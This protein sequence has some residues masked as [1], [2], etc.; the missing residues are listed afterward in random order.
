MV[1]NQDSRRRY[2]LLLDLVLCCTLFF[3]G[4]ST[5]EIYLKSMKGLPRMFPG[6]HT[7]WFHPVVLLA[8]GRGYVRITKSFPPKLSEFLEGKSDVFSCEDLPAKDKLVTTSPNSFDRH[9][10]YLMM[11]IAF[12]WRISGVITWSGLIPLLSF[13]F[14]I[15]IAASY[16]IFRLGMGRVL[17]VSGATLLAFSGMHLSNLIYLRDFSKEP[18]FLVFIFILVVLVTQ[19]LVNP[20]KLLLISAALGAV[21]GIGFGFRHDTFILIPLFIITVLFF[22]PGS[23]KCHI[24]IK[25]A[26]IA[27]FATTFC[28]VGYKPLKVTSSSV[29]TRA[30]FH[31]TLLGLNTRITKNLGLNNSLYDFGNIY[32]DSYISVV[33]HS[34]SEVFFEDKDYSRRGTT[35]YN[36]KEGR[37]LM[38]IV[39][40]FPADI[41]VRTYAAPLS[42]LDLPFKYNHFKHPEFIKKIKP[43]RYVDQAL[44]FFKG[45]GVFLSVLAV[46]VISLSNLRIG[47]FLFFLI[48]YLGGYTVVQFTGRHHFHLE[49]LSLWTLG[50]LLQKVIGFFVALTHSSSRDSV[51]QTISK[52]LESLAAIRKPLAVF[53]L[54]ISMFIMLLFLLRIY[55]TKNVQNMIQTISSMETEKFELE[56]A[57]NDNP[58]K[59]IVMG[60]IL[61]NTKSNMTQY[62]VVEIG[63]EQC[64]TR[65]KPIGLRLKGTLYPHRDWTIPVP[66]KG[67]TIKVFSPLYYR[68]KANTIQVT[69]SKKHRDCLLSVSRIKSFENLP[70]LLNFTMP[71]DW[72][73]YPLYQTFKWEKSKSS[74]N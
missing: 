32:S 20:K 17:S 46:F 73:S 65:D 60:R 30:R 69:I 35:D 68:R 37:Y 41:L 67:E 19:R 58:K 74:T 28:I 5:G 39:K 2:G 55:Q 72:K 29:D 31:P 63:G 22:L 42:V 48:L 43:L 40:N 59:S 61:N 26:A 33:A 53:T 45:K 7:Q 14:G 34:Y 11:L 51:F 23:V 12:V 56:N 25:I 36:E 10:T 38:G 18:F 6:R 52:P 44:Q 15:S 4:Y 13:M 66:D 54:A 64:D 50:F 3:A 21:I 47:I 16:G 8:C 57:P 49:F 9:H 1:I 70:F 27:L 71:S 62:I 24:N